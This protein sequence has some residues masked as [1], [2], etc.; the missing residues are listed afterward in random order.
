M[1]VRRFRE[2]L[3]RVADV[4]L[5]CHDLFPA[6]QGPYEELMQNVKCP[7]VLR[8]AIAKRWSSRPQYAV[9][10]DVIQRSPMD[11]TAEEEEDPILFDTLYRYLVLLGLPGQSGH[12]SAVE[13]AG[14]WLA[15]NCI[16]RVC[17]HQLLPHL[18]PKSNRKGRS[19]VAAR[20]FAA[21]QAQFSLAF[22]SA[23]CI[24]RARE[25]LNS[26][27]GMLSALQDMLSYVPS[28]RPAMLQ[29]L[30][31]PIFEQLQCFS[32]EQLRDGAASARQCNMLYSQESLRRR[33]EALADL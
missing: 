2:C 14:E 21:D 15:D 23:A 27:P 33:G 10:V 26:V 13:R 8:Y 9:I 29:L 12:C 31:G 7:D 6:V 25:R 30:K 17:A 32:S 5:C 3:K 28:E 22:G 11:E 18:L 24:V 19:P 4:G 16:W 20:Q 1:L